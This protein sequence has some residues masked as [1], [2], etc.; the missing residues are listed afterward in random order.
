MIG[1]FCKIQSLL[2]GS[3]AKETYNCKEPT[4]CSHPI[5]LTGPQI[6]ICICQHIQSICVRMNVFMWKSVH[7]HIPTVCDRAGSF[8]YM[9]AS[10]ICICTCHHICT[11]HHV[12]SKHVLMNAFMQK[13]V[14]IDVWGGYNCRL[15]KIIGLF[16]RILSLLQGSFA[17]ETY[18]FKE[19]TNRSHPIPTALECADMCVYMCM[20]RHHIWFIHVRMHAIMQ[21]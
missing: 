8:L 20:Y 12:W 5:T 9:V 13:T 17:K 3:F 1:L 10:Y 6:C 21:K 16:Y 4:N 7:I 18:I 15:L 11:Y 19:P 2:Q 14:N